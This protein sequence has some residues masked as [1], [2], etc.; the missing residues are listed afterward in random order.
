MFN[1]LRNMILLPSMNNL[2]SNILQLTVNKYIVQNQ[3]Y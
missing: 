2:I 3:R 1:E